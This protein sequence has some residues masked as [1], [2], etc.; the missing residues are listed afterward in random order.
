MPRVFV[1][2]CALD[3]DSRQASSIQKL[4]NPFFTSSQSVSAGEED[5]VHTAGTMYRVHY[6]IQ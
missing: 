2:L 6:S 5:S 3:R 1:H 4:I